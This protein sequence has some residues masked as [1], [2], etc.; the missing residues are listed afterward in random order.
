MT[1]MKPKL[2]YIQAVDTTVTLGDTV[3]MPYC[4]D[5]NSLHG[6]A[7]GEKIEVPF[8]RMGVLSTSMVKRME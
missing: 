4:K 1:A 3:Y 2:F 7:V 8:E 5:L 6:L